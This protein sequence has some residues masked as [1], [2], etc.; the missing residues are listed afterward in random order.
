MLYLDVDAIVKMTHWRLLEHFPGVTHRSWKDCSTVTALR[1]R[2][3]KDT[4]KAE[5][6][7]H[8]REDAIYALQ[9]LELMSPATGQIDENVLT[10][11]ISSHNID[12]GEAVLLGYVA[13]QEGFRFVTGDK[14]AVKALSKTSVNHLFKGKIICVEQVF[15]W[16]LNSFGRR[17]MLERV[18][19]QKN[20]DRNISIILGSQCDAKEADIRMGLD[21]SIRALRSDSKDVL[22][23]EKMAQPTL[24]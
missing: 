14:R 2:A 3:K 15:L 13:L 10:T 4:K 19:P 21:S 12:S 7:F 24:N 9:F 5:D 23:Q 17:W 8:S 20:I 6:L 11:L 16:F 22:I 1:A 18:C